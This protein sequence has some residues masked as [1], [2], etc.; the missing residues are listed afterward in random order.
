MVCIRVLDTLYSLLGNWLRDHTS[1]ASSGIGVKIKSLPKN[2][3]SSVL[4]FTISRYTLLF[5]YLE[6]YIA[7]VIY[8]EWSRSI[9]IPLCTC[10]FPSELALE[11]GFYNIELKGDL[12]SLINSLKDGHRSLAQYGHIVTNIHYLASQFSVFNL[13]YA[14]RHC[15]KVAHS[16]ARRALVSPFP[17][18]SRWK[19][20]LQMSLMFYMLILA[21]YLNKMFM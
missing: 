12:A 4:N 18:Q 9:I 21:H 11:L 13:S 15:N 8:Y 20:Y 19:M 14:R 3:W 5:S 10:I 6:I 2:F 17:C 1:W 7:H 16:L